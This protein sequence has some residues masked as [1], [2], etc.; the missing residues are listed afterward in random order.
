VAL[1]AVED[2]LATLLADARPPQMS[3]VVAIDAAFGRIAATAIHSSI[4]V[5]P[6]DNSAMDGYAVRAADVQVGAPLPVSQRIPAGAIG[7]PLLPGTAA[8]I[9]TGA[10]L[11]PGADTVVMQEDCA[12]VEGGVVIA[13]QPLLGDNVRPQGQD[14]SR[15]ALL[16]ERGQHL[17]PVQV[18]LLG[19]VGIARVA[20]MPTLRV[21]LFSTGDELVEPGVPLQAGQIYNSNRLLLAGMLRN[22]GCEVRDL[23]IVRDTAAD[24]AAA[25]EAAVTDSDCVISTGGVSAGEEDHVRAQLE[26]LGELKLWKLNIKPG[27]P[28]AYARLRDVPFFGLPGNPVSAFV[29]FSILVRPFLA[30]LQGREASTI[31]EQQLPAAFKWARPG[32]RQEYLRARIV[33][34]DGRQV[35]EVF[36]NQSSGV[37]TSVAWAN[38]LVVVSPGQTIEPGDDVTTLPLD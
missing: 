33:V 23:G 9:F 25:L 37:L 19:S 15:G 21:A 12:L 22:L 38:A 29:T 3:E 32:S 1:I 8:R 6:A 28:L 17:G 26:R 11:P 24:T 13:I 30:R 10:E 20:V 18:A 36:S 14:I 31:R 34:R 4:D 35:V 16:V 2:A 5:P 27:K 7:S